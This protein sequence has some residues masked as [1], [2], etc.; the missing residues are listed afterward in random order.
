MSKVDK[1]AATAL[2]GEGGRLY[3]VS[4]LLGPGVFALRAAA[5]SRR[6]AGQHIVSSRGEARLSDFGISKA[7]TDEE[8]SAKTMVGTFRYMAPERLRGDAYSFES[9]VWAA[10]MVLLELLRGDAVFPPSCTPLDLNGACERLARDFVA[11]KLEGVDVSTD[12]VDF[13]EACLR[14]RAEDRALRKPRCW[15]APG[16]RAWTSAG[17][18][19]DPGALPGEPAIGGGGAAAA[20][21]A[22]AAVVDLRRGPEPHPAAN[23]SCPRTTTTRRRWRGV[24]RSFFQFFA[25]GQ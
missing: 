1:P 5:T 10:G 19:C 11:E 21:A 25:S 22:R 24:S 7:L 6:Q 17:L 18:L 8:E 20:R 14:R 12:C 16:S 15:P 3:I 23:R 4:V 13:A 9:D 2:P